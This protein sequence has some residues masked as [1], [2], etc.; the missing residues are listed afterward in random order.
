MKITFGFDIG[1]A[2]I[3]WAA[4]GEKEEGNDRVI[5]D[6]GVRIVPL[7]TDEV[8]EFRKGG[9]VPTN[10]AR[11]QA[12][13]ARR[14]LQRFRLRRSALIRA[15][16]QLGMKP[17]DRLYRH[18][19]PAELFSLRDRAIQETLSLPEIG[20]IFLHLNL[21]RGFRSSRKTE[22][23]K[24]ESEYKEE[25]KQ[26]E[27][28]LAQ[29]QQ[30]IGQRFAAGLKNDPN[31]RVRQQ[32][33]NRSSYL[34]EFD[35]IWKF[36]S[37]AHPEVMTESA[38][39]RLRDKIIYMQRPLKSAKGLV[40]ECTLEW[41]Y[42]LDKQTSQPILMD[43]GRNKIVRPKCAPKSSPLAQE[44]NLWESIHNIRITDER[45]NNYPLTD[46]HKRQIFEILQQEEKGLS[47]SRL[48]KDI[49]KIST[50]AYS[51]DNL[52]DTKGL[53][54]NK[55]R[56]K[57]LTIF[58]KTGVNRPDLLQFDPA[59]E[60]VEWDN[61]ADG[62]RISRLQLRGDFDQ[63]PLYKLWH[64]IYA[65]QEESDLIRILQERYQF[66]TEQAKELAAL[67]FTAAGYARKSH[68]AMRR[69]LPHYRKGLD[70]TRA[71][72]AAG[73]NH[74]N[75]ITKAENMGRDLLTKLDVI[76]KNSLR[77]P[78]VEKILNQLV[79]VVNELLTVYGN[80]DEICVEL[81]REL[82][83]SA[84]ERQ[85][86]TKQNYQRE[87]DHKQYRN[88]IAELL[89]IN[90]ASVT[91][92]Q[93]EK[94]KLGLETDWQSLYTG[95]RIDMATFL[96][97]EQVDVEHIIPRVRR[98]DDS[99]GN[100]TICESRINQ[101]KGDMTAHDFMK[102]QR[103]AGIQPYEDYLRMV[104]SLLDDRKIS[105]SKFRN[106]MMTAED[107]A[108][109]KDFLARQLR[110]TQ[111]ITSTARTMLMEVTRTVRTTSGSITDFL[112]HAWGWD[113][114]IHNSRLDQFRQIGATKEIL[115][116]NG[117][118]TKEVIKDW[119]KRKDH[120]HHA[121]DALVTACT[122]QAH[123][124][125]LNNLNQALE[126]R[127]GVERRNELRQAG[128]RDKYLAGPVP[129]RKSTVLEAMENVLV[130]YK[131]SNKVATRS[132][133]N[134]KGSKKG[135]QV[136]L[137]PRGALH[138]ETIYGKIKRYAEKP[139]PLNSKFKPEWIEKIAH[140]HQRLLVQARL[141]EFEGDVKKAF[142]DLEKHPVLYGKNGNKKLK[143]VTLWEEWYVA[144]EAIGTTTSPKKVSLIVDGAVKKNVQ[145]RLNDAEG[146]IKKAFSNTTTEPI[147]AHKTPVR[148]ARILNPAEQMI[149]L[150]RGYAKSDGNHH[151]AIYRDVDGKKYEHVVSYWD[152]FNR[153]RVGLPAIIKDVAKSYEYIEQYGEEIPDNLVLPV[154]PN[155]Q[156]VVSLAINDM[157]IFD[158]NESDI[159]FLAHN[160]RKFIS[161]NLFR[162]RKLTSGGY[163]FLHHLETELLEDLDSKKINRCKQCSVSSL[164][165]AVKVKVDRTG[166]IIAVESV[167]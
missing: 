136:T 53:E 32:I 150:P 18:L 70:Y 97:G 141:D 116:K 17:D 4:I 110:E 161:K 25:I 56:A 98:F 47:A 109:D 155:W 103:S 41:N 159:D 52:M 107:V 6:C 115:I 100:K 143:A 131:Q 112:R 162:V 45:G 23:D 20:R 146:D 113:E 105:K 29:Q 157:F 65:T 79:H 22:T 120:R 57:I 72:E 83:Q 147:F 78:V 163:W 27:A 145:S 106:L 37:A 134:P 164:A 24:K 158:I 86:V 58:K 84:S 74:S 153:I 5:L 160:N 89:D 61:P 42:A 60:T 80:P 21:R 154:N 71:C 77:N 63:Q 135:K 121:L 87:R 39:K 9:S 36:Q 48:L 126:G 95:K 93:I 123:V 165:G 28:E 156:F 76:P 64:L 2:S 15:L 88:R 34:D 33:F 167:F 11:R 51:V 13:G 68:R 59:V 152:A 104:K 137:T 149:R 62:A 118:K 108:A 85:E 92:S 133:N 148:S 140:D 30:T 128:G 122:T 3:G 94:W 35:Q 142:K 55:T 12:R 31:Y 111:Y 96:L 10:V 101:E 49:L 138:K 50:R 127:E 66:T 99:F 144:R 151:I 90:T 125:R 82:R 8:D 67:D 19:P 132:R 139:T 26:R 73:Y 16:D 166:K 117:T 1:V 102:A 129:F 40:G 38:R 75:S 69:L 43:N 54:G 124:Q 14:G 130:S 7:A 91:K 114:I 81:A 46:E 119:N 44:C